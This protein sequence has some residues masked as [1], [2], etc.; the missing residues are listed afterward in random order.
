MAKGPGRHGADSGGVP[1]NVWRENA[2]H[3]WWVYEEEPRQPWAAWLADLAESG[4][5]LMGW[6]AQT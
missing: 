6:T 5:H 4:Q 2:R 1:Q 3:L